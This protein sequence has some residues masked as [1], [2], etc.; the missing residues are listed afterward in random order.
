MFKGGYVGVR[1]CVCVGACA[2][3]CTHIYTVYLYIKTGIG[4]GFIS[5]R[6]GLHLY[7]CLP[8]FNKEEIIKHLFPISVFLLLY[9]WSDTRVC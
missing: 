1:K 8:S 3:V 4:N 6:H 7:P 2:C 9:I 5:Q